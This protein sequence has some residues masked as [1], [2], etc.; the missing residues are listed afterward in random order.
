[1]TRLPEDPIV[2]TQAV[3]KYLH[4]QWPTRRIDTLGPL[5]LAVADQLVDLQDLYRV[6]KHSAEDAAVILQEFVDEIITAEQMH[7]V[8]LPFEVVRNK[9][10]PRIQPIDYFIDRRADLIAHQPY[11]NDTVILYVIDINQMPTPVTTEQLVRWGISPEEL[12]ELARN[13]LAAAQPELEI[14]LYESEHHPAALLSAG[15]GYDASRLLLS[16]L[17]DRLAPE[18]GRDF[19]VAIPSRDVFI[20]FPPGPSHFVERLKKQVEVDFEQLPYPITSRLFLVTR[21]GVADWLDAA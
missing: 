21:D 16:Q 11:V 5:K 4:K 17:H 2:F 6:C 1:M 7:A 14:Q 3:V 20:A 15:D 13:N 18:L 8:P 12:D 19:L 9:L 10:M